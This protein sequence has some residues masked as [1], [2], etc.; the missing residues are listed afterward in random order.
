MK[1]VFIY[2]TTAALLSTTA[3]FAGGMDRSG[4]GI[5]ALFE[6]GDYAEI[7][8]GTVSPSISGTS[9]SATNNVGLDYTQTSLAYKTDLDDKLSVAV[10]FDQPYGVDLEYTGSFFAGTKAGVDSSAITGILR[11]KANENLSFHGGLRYQ[12][13][14]GNLTMAS[15]FFGPLNG[16]SATF[17]DDSGF[18]YLV[19]GAYERSDIAL[20]VA[21]T[22]YS[23][24]E[25]NMA[26]AD[27]YVASSTTTVETPDAW[28]L[29]FQTGIAKD[30]LMFGSIRFANWGDFELAPAGAGGTNLVS[31]GDSTTYNLGVGRR[32]SDEFSASLSLAYEASGGDMVSPL[33]P[34]D[35]KFGVTLGGRYTMDNVTISGGINYTEVGDA[36]IQTA[37][38]ARGTFSGNSVMGLGVKVGYSF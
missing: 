11:Y 28:N 22:Y 8:Y 2:G 4:Q 10:I 25:H 20:R 13:I 14:S 32:F 30:T 34:T 9:V 35:G 16:F 21:L 7:S 33:A 24:V 5:S 6:A 17:D 31:L 38:T 23:S 3:A 15:A 12:T 36:T 1:N 29:D 18:G 19:G 27:T 37:D 26:T